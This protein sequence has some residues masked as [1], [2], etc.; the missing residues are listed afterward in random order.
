M[1]SAEAWLQHSAGT[2]GNE[3]DH[4]TPGNERQPRNAGNGLC[5]VP[6]FRTGFGAPTG[7]CFALPAYKVPI[8][9]SKSEFRRFLAKR[10]I[11]FNDLLSQASPVSW[12]GFLRNH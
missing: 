9:T 3:R 6:R 11:S 5:A 10:V 12:R 1:W 7:S 4:G 8:L 2:P